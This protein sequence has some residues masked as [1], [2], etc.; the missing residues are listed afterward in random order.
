[1]LSPKIG[2][3]PELVDMVTRVA[4]FFLFVFIRWELMGN[5]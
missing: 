3:K 4:F 1:M 2:N 5:G